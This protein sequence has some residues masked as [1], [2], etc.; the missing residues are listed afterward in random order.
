MLS[1]FSEKYSLVPEVHEP[2]NEIIKAQIGESLSATY[3]EKYGVLLF[4]SL[5]WNWLKLQSDQHLH[6]VEKYSLL[7]HFSDAIL[8]VLQGE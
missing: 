6:C 2:A 4:L 3:S 8:L 7:I 1:V 5:L